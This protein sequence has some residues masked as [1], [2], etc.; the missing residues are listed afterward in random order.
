MSYRIDPETIVYLQ[1]EGKVLAK[2]HLTNDCVTNYVASEL[3]LELSLFRGGVL[4]VL[5][6]EVGAPINRFRIADEKLGADEENLEVDDGF[7]T[8]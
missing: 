3:S 1:D 8:E 5:I 7:K 2:L 6:D 4:R